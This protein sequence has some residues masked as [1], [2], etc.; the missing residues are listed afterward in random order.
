MFTDLQYQIDAIKDWLAMIE[1]HNWVII[2][3]VVWLW[4]SII[5]S[6]IINNLQ[7]NAIIMCPPHLKDQW[8]EYKQLFNIRAT[9]FSSGKIKDARNFDIKYAN[10][11]WV[12]L[13]DEAHKY[14]NDDTIDYW[15]LHQICQWKKVILLTATPFIRQG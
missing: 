13:I 3:D 8:E 4:K 11:Y 2:A 7:E 5:W 1:K 15:Y 12:I 6:T 9:I 14:V 10:K